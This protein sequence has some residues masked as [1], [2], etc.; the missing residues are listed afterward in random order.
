MN[1]LG[2][3]ICD[4]QFRFMPGRSPT[5]ALR[6]T[7]ERYREGQELENNLEVWGFALGMKEKKM[8]VTE[9]KMLHFSL[10]LTRR[11][12]IR[13]EKVREVLSGGRFEG[14]AKVEAM[15]VWARGRRDEECVGN[16]MLEMKPPGKRK[17]GRPKRR[18]M[19]TIN[20]DMAQ[21]GVTGMDVQDR[22]K[23]RRMIRCGDP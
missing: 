8:E 3:V 6:L 18:H 23:W 15:M 22:L 16:R 7:M 9:I 1:G 10:G 21:V 4:Q 11:N 2:F 20:E 12:R 17:R 13:N 14:N 5:D 19:D